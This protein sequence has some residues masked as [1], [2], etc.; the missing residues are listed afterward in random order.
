[1]KAHVCHADG[2]VTVV[3]FGEGASMGDAVTDVTHHDGVWAHHRTGDESP[4]SVSSDTPELAKAL[5][6]HFGCVVIEWEG[7]AD[8]H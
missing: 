1:M 6:E 3:E 4:V 7:N 5:S 8:A 2:R